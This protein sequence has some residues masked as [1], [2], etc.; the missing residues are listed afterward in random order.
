MITDCCVFVC[1]CLR[2]QEL[3]AIGETSESGVTT[4]QPAP[5][6]TEANGDVDPEHTDGSTVKKKKKKKKNKMEEERMEEEVTDPTSDQL[7]GN[8][9]TELTKTVNEEKGTG[10]RK[11]KRK[12]D[13]HLKQEEMEQ[14]VQVSAVEVHCSDSSG[15]QSDKPCK[16]RKHE[17]AADLTE[18]VD[19]PKPKKSKKRKSGIEQCA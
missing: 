2:V 5:S 14:E 16:K 19:S 17:A 6:D 3:L 13:K 12:K 8:A 4:D 15:Y 11:K 9:T 10:D 1:M 18:T 7:D